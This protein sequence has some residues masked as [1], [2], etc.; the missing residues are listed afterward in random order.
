MFFHPFQV[1]SCF[2][3]H[4]TDSSQLRPSLATL[5]SSLSLPRRKAC[6]SAKDDENATLNV[7]TLGQTKSDNINRSIAITGEFYWVIFYKC[8]HIKSLLTLTSN[9]IKWFS[10]YYKYVIHN[11]KG[12]VPTIAI[13]FRYFALLI[14]ECKYKLHECM[15]IFLDS[16]NFSTNFKMQN[17]I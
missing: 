14:Q 15:L 6:R 11:S 9:C 3:H 10:M 7:I 13:R 12:S 17:S 2:S 4:S 1:F 8:D 16:N 5:W